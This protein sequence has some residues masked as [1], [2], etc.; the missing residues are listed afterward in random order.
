MPTLSQKLLSG[1]G[2]SSGLSP[3][4]ASAVDA[5]CKSAIRGVKTRILEEGRA[6]AAKGR[7]EPAREI[8]WGKKKIWW[9]ILPRRHR[10][11]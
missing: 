8:G 4:E 9:R 1:G 11:R 3:K 6:L 2:L 5:G 10:A 7:P